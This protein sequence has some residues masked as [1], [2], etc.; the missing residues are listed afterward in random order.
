MTGSRR[1]LIVAVAAPVLLVMTAGVLPAVA[2]GN[3]FIVSFEPGTSR[4]SR[5]A[6][7]ARHGVGLRFNYGIIDA[8]AVTLPNE[9]ARRGLLGEGT[10]RSITPDFPVFASQLD[11]APNSGKSNGKPG[12]GS[13]GGTT[14]SGEVIPPGVQRV[15]PPSSASNGAG[16]GVAIV[17]TGIDLN[18]AD[19]A[20]VVAGY[21]AVQPTANCMDDNGHGTH[22]AG[23]VAALV[24][25][26]DVIG[27][28]PAASLYCV[29]VLNAQGSG[30]WAT[31]ISGLDWIYNGGVPRTPAIRVVNMSLGGGGTDEASPLRDAIARLHAMGIVVVVAA[32]NDASLD[33]SEQV[34]AAYA[35]SKYVVTVASTT[36]QAGTTVTGCPLA[37]QADAAS[38]FTSD[39]VDVTVSGPGNEKENITKKGPFCY[40][41]SVGILSLKL[42]GGTTRMSGTSM[43]T[44]H[45]SGIVARLLQSPSSYAGL[46]ANPTPEHIRLYLIDKASRKNI[47]P[48][49]SPASSYTFDTIREGVAVIP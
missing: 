19:L 21:N 18:Q 37:I 22:V 13:N 8:I 32:G 45:V 43:S 1:S 31:I 15:G 12:S 42:G 9:N 44:P 10:V 49:D 3:D 34:P 2:Q 4:A 30:S 26:R 6:A 29:K 14:P 5:A 48:L 20:P 47:A 46:A 17:D 7:A 24:N 23:T 16:I 33:V 25:N 27:V 39:G 38:Y 11:V 36:A 28:A 40:L 41:N 35:R